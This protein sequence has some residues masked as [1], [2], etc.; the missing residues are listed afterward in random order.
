MKS[1]NSSVDEA[2]LSIMNSHEDTEKARKKSALPT[3][4]DYILMALHAVIKAYMLKDGSGDKI[5]KRN[6]FLP[7]VYPMGS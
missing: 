4:K 5:S 1:V 6:P 3:E 2:L 7:P